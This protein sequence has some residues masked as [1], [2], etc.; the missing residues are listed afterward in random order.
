MSSR[1]VLRVIFPSWLLELT[2]R[3]SSKSARHL[4]LAV[5]RHP[6]IHTQ[7]KTQKY[8]RSPVLLSLSIFK[9]TYLLALLVH[10]RCC[11]RVE[12]EK[13]LEDQES[14]TTERR[15]S[16]CFA[17]YVS[18]GSRVEDVWQ[19]FSYFRGT[20]GRGICLLQWPLYTSPAFLAPVGA[21]FTQRKPCHVQLVQSVWYFDCKKY[22]KILNIPF[23]F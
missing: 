4:W 11:K 23:F 3:R 17:V 1:V 9:R 6:C 21:D 5:K 12:R 20:W 10:Y 22:K 14:A 2:E 7:P 8:V 13:M 19:S 16:W 18:V 15:G